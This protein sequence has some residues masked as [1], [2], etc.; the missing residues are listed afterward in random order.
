[1]N[2]HSGRTGRHLLTGTIRIFLAEALILPTGFITAIYLARSL[3]PA[4]YG[5]FALVSR[6]FS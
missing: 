4:G 5:I 6:S 2:Q 1:M 3:G